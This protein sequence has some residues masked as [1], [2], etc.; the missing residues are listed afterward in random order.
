VNWVIIIC[1]SFFLSVGS[2]VYFKTRRK[3]SQAKDILGNKYDRLRNLL[4]ENLQVTS[5]KYASKTLALNV[6][7]KQDVHT[8][9]LTEVDDR[10]IVVWTLNSAAFGKRG[11][12]WSFNTT[13]SQ[14]KM[15]EEIVADIDNYK[16][17]LYRER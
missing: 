16:K 13:Y 4:R 10:L 2:L 8:Y 5:E 3:V 15:F 9:A 6:A 12:E 7:D 1:A 14:E 17:M 11:K